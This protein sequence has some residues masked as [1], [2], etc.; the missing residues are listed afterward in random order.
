M[1]TLFVRENWSRALPVY[2]YPPT[3]EGQ[4]LCQHGHGLL[5]SLHL[6]QRHLGLGQPEG[7]VHDTVQREGGRQ[8][9]VSLFPLAGGGVQSTEAELAV[10]QERTH[11]EFLSQ[12]EGL[13]VVDFGLL[14]LWRLTPRRNLAQEVQSI[15]LFAAFLI[16]A[17]ERPRPLGEGERLCQVASQQLG[18]PQGGTTERLKS[19]PFRCHTL[20]HHLC[21]Q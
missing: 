7:H 10:R 15:R 4:A 20:L 19:Y 1:S 9:G 17:G 11:A 6:R 3:S 2:H 21:E 18:L 5:P 12:G 8:F 13:A 14:A 16:L